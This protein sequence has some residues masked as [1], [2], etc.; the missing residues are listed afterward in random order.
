MSDT[1]SSASRARRSVVLARLACLILPLVFATASAADDVLVFAAASLKPALDTILDT[2]AARAV[3][4]V[5]V[6]YAATSQLARQIKHAAPASIFISADPDWMDQVEKDGHII[7]GTRS[8]LL[9]NA[10]VLIAPRAS[11]LELAIAPGF[12]LAGALGKDARLAMGEPNSVPA[13]RYAKAALISLGVWNQ[14]EDRIVPAMHV[15]A[16]LNFVVRNEAPLGIVYRSD[17]VSEERVRVIGAFAAS[18][19]PTIVYPAALLR[20]GDNEAS[21]QLFEVLHSAQAAA[22]F[23]RFGFDV[24]AS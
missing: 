24:P 13:G 18:T 21:R 22:I 5:A 15:R 7:P 9:G 3:G 23:A 11:T 16:A 2:P 20:D 1:A 10:L 17:A 19:H 8:N 12:D 14:V 4:E 6:S